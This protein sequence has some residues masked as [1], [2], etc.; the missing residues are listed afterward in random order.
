MAASVRDV[1]EAIKA[2]PI[3]QVGLRGWSFVPGSAE[4][5]AAI[6]LPPEVTYEGLADNVLEMQIT[7]VVL[8][9]ASVDKHQ[10][11]LLEFMDDLGPNS[12]PGAFHADP[13]LGL[14]GV[15][16]HVLRAYPL[17]FEQQAAYQAYGAAFEV[18]VYL[19][20]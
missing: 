14:D 5:P 17:N 11:R 20:A 3:A 10:L 6:V 16:A 8:I 1:V 7:V 18:K 13:S 4:V 9:S 15:S 19:R 12:L 2:G